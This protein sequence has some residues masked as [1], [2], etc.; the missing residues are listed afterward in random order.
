[1]T[2]GGHGHDACLGPLASYSQAR[3]S[4]GG[5]DRADRHGDDLSRA[6]TGAG[7]GGEEGQIPFGPG[8]WGPG[9]GYGGR[10]HDPLQ[11]SQL[12]GLGGPVTA[13]GPDDL[14]QGIDVQ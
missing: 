4:V 2:S 10:G 1:V 9:V 12:Q 6:Q 3:A 11:L 5:L 7:Q 13:L 14:L 8:V